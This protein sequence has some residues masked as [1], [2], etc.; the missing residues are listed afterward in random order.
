M[1]DASDRSRTLAD[2]VSRRALVGA[3][4]FG[5]GFSGLIDVL[6]LHLILQWHHLLSGIYT[7]DTLA[8]LRTNI[9]ADGWFSVGMVVIAGIGAGVIWRAE[10][11]TREPL[12][13][14]PIAGSAVMG[15]GAF[16]LYDVIVDHALLDLHQPLSMG[17]QYNPHWAIVSLLI[18]GAGAYIYRTATG[19]DDT[20]RT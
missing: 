20:T 9:L 14:R 3:G 12:A 15:L 2:G 16:D 18:I 19:T 10:R 13:I 11:R 8:G 7:M 5:F 4:V 1:S 6:L 17:G